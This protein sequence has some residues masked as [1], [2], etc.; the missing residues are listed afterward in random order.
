MTARAAIVCL[1]L[2]PAVPARA[3]NGTLAQAPP[4]A[5]APST[6]PQAAPA[7]SLTLDFANI[8]PAKVAD[9]RALQELRG[10][11]RN[12][13]QLMQSMLN[14]LRPLMTRSLPPGDYRDKLI[15][16]YMQKVQTMDLA[17]QILDAAVPIYDKYL[18]DDDIKGLIQFYQSPVGRKLTAVTPALM[19]ELQTISEKRGEDM[20]R[21]AMLDVLDENPDLKKALQD[22]ANAAKTQ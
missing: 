9:I 19:T 17:Q 16:L 4:A 21:Q 20:G 2:L 14:T 6:A 10:D 12:A 7:H 13:D 8:D 11:K 5:S 18:S 1:L 3:Q 22:A 15:D